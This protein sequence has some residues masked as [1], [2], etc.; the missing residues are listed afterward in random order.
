MPPCTMPI[1]WH[2]PGTTGS[3]AVRRPTSTTSLMSR[4]IT[5]MKLSSRATRVSNGTLVTRSM[6]RASEESTRSSGTWQSHHAITTLMYRYAECIDAADFDGIASIFAHGRI[7]NEGVEGEIAGP[8][9]V[10]AL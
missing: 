9:A 4:P 2:T 3:R 6:L 7:T 1:G 5:P 8:D 10:R